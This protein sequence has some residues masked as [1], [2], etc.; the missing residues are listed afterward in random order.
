MRSGLGRISLLPGEFVGW[1]IGAGGAELAA[2]VILGSRSPLL[3][4]IA[5]IGG[6]GLVFAA[7]RPLLALVIMVVAEVTNASG[8][9]ATRTGIPIFQATVLLG[10]LAV[11]LALRE[12]Q[13]RSRFNGWTWV[14]IALLVVYLATQGVATLGSDDMSVSV[15]AMYRYTV[16]LLF[17]ALLIL[18]VQIT[19]RPWTVAAAVVVSFAVLSVLTAI[20]QFVFGGAQDFGGFSVV[21]E[22]SG[23]LTT[24][25]RYGGPLPD[26][27]FWGRHLIMGLPLAA[28]LLTKALRAG[29]RIRSGWWVGML[30]AQL[31]GIYLTQSRGTFMAAGLAMVVWFL[32]SE[33]SVRKWGL[34]S[35]PLAL[36]MLAVPGVGN[37]LEAVV[38][39]ITHTS[40]DMH[41]DP[42]VLGRLAAQEEAWMMW[43]QRPLFGWGPH[44]FPGEVWRFAGLVATAVREPTNAPH[45]VYLE[46]L[47]ESGVFGLAGWLV[48]IVGFVTVV[49]L[50]IISRPL[51]SE[52]VLAAAVCAAII[53]WSIASIGLHLTY[54][55]TLGVMLA[56][57]AALAPAW[58]VPG[59][60]VRTLMRGVG[61]W[62]T[63][64]VLGLAVG[65]VCLLFES[66]P[67]VQANQSVT[68]DPV[69]PRYGWYA[70]ALDIRSRAEFL[71]TF[72]LLLHDPNSAVVLNADPVRGLLIFTATGDG[73]D[74]ARDQIQL[75][76]GHADS[77]LH[78]MVGYEQYSLQPVGSMRVSPTSSHPPEASVIAAG[79]GVG[80]AVLTGLALSSLYGHRRRSDDRQHV[81]TAEGALR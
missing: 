22:A 52:R 34:A 69:G 46:L 73:L 57:A 1:A 21:T 3:L 13:A 16:D 6:I 63:A 65:W 39:D 50:R 70:Y 9:L 4:L 24:T 81:L 19:A 54:L 11:G 18:L 41:V 62:A 58:P 31:A 80:T 36:L 23:A 56:L 43:Q 76:I 10:V 38:Y 28:A 75:A 2:V 35:L 60:A 25:L 71:P 66:K 27:N 14:C 7:R 44:T 61:V 78:T 74:Q 55:R 33:S 67:A 64:L 29:C 51:A 45:N 32:A 77:Q 8:V 48:M 5:P 15:D 12:P 17:T 49:V 26:S 20:D 40:T 68:L 37:R 79:S 47:A 42:S 30:L 59:E 53:G 72:A